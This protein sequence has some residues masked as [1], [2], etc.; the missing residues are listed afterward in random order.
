M[1]RRLIALTRDPLS[2]LG[3]AITTASAV[4]FVSLFAM[5][6]A[7]FH[8][9]PYIGILAYLILPALF[10]FGLVLI[11]LGIW[12]GRRRA[13]RAA[14]RARRRRPTRCSTSTS[15]ARARCSSASSSSR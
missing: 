3:S 11:P 7:G 13:R 2:L 14:A 8:G 1:R 10:L 15:G 5:E 4:I 9:G 6:L 12:R